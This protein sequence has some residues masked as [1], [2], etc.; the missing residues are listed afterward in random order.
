M[1]LEKEQNPIIINE[2]LFKNNKGNKN[3]EIKK[4]QSQS[5]IVYQKSQYTTKNENIFKFSN[6]KMMMIQVKKNQLK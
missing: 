4:S 3:K 6:K 1:N 2:K 5:H